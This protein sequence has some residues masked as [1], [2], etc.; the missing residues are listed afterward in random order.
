MKRGI[1]NGLVRIFNN[2]F[3]ADDLYEKKIKQ[4]AEIVHCAKHL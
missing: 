3:T 2:Y 1:S 4:K